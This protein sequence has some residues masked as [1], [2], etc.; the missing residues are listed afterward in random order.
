[1]RR[2]FIQTL[3]IFAIALGAGL[4]QFG[5]HLDPPVVSSDPVSAQLAMNRG[6]NEH[7]MAATASGC[8]VCLMTFGALCLVVPWFNVALALK[9]GG[10]TRIA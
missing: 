6:D 4:F 2:G 9:T 10:E 1:M 7:G 5:R 3:A 8:G